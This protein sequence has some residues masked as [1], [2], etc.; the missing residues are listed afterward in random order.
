MLSL[1]EEFSIREFPFIATCMHVLYV[2]ALYVANSLLL[3]VAT[4]S[5]RADGEKI[6]YFTETFPQI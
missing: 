5:A 6:G 3:P 4:S 2:I 1:Q